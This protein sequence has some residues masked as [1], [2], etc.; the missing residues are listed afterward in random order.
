MVFFPFVPYLRGQSTERPPRTV[1][2]WARRTCQSSKRILIVI[3]GR[4]ASACAHHCA[5]RLVV[6][7]FAGKLH[8]HYATPRVVILSLRSLNLSAICL[9]GHG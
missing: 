2:M 3:V 9:L 6:P 4:S 5:H 7:A 8:G 1:H